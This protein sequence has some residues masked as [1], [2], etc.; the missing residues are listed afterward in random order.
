MT[1]ITKTA[2]GIKDVEN[3]TAQTA[4]EKGTKDQ[5][6]HLLTKLLQTRLEKM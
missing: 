1:V 4:S 3:V 5:Q 2:G 6:A